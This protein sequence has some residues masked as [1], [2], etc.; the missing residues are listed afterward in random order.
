M[1]DEE[2]I[3]YGG[4]LAQHASVAMAGAKAELQFD[5]ALSSRDTIG[6]AKGIL[7]ERF[8]VDD[9]RAF[10]LL[11][12]LSQDGNIKLIEIAKRVIDTHTAVD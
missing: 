3:L 1:F 7:M 9:A 4:I 2:S 8:G 11:L 6:Q 10:A 12:K 5:R